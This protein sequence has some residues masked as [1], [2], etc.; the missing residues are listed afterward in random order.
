MLI[1]PVPAF[2]TDSERLVWSQLADTLEPGEVLFHG[3]RFTDARDGDIEIDLLLL[4]PER[5]AAIVEV[6][7]GLVQY[8][9]G[10]WTLST[11]GGSSRRIHPVEQ[12]RRAKHALRRY[13]DRCP[14][15]DFGL[16]RSQWFL[17]LPHTPVDGDLGPEA[18]RERVMGQGD[19]PRLRTMLN[20]GLSDAPR[21]PPVPPTD[22]V[23]LAI[24]LLRNAPEASDSAERFGRAQLQGGHGVAGSL[25]LVGVGLGAILGSLLAV[26]YLGAWGGFIAAALICAAVVVG[27]RFA[28]SRS[29]VPLWLAIAVVIVCV[30]IGGLVGIGFRQGESPDDVEVALSP[31]ARTTVESTGIDVAQIPCSTAYSPCVREMPWNRNCEDIGFR[32][33]LLGTDDPFSLDRDRDGVGCASFPESSRGEGSSDEQSDAGN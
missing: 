20:V 21:E 17:A 27:Y 12:A 33:T 6:K 19:L 9:E 30:L 18:P 7:G 22:W 2:Q 5:G 26:R 25:A 29:Q 23:P 3:L 14:E 32:V 11:N 24:Q 13:L 16:L 28:R 15:W 8:K 1:P 31:S 10:E 4:S